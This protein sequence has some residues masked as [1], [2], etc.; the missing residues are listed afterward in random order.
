MNKLKI[1]VFIIVLIIGI[2]IY[3]Y[4][5]QKNTHPGATVIPAYTPAPTISMADNSTEWKTYTNTE[6]KYSFQYPSDF[7]LHIN[8]IHEF[9]TDH[10]YNPSPNTLELDS[11]VAGVIPSIL[12]S[13]KEVNSTF[14]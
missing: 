2:V 11:S 9:E 8:E 14:S 12:I 5:T 3:A 1:A 7:E 13:H 10:T 6:G 4:L